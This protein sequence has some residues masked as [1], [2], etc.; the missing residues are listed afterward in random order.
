MPAPQS[1]DLT[2]WS[3]SDKLQQLKR[4]QAGDLLFIPGHVMMVLGVIDGEVWVIHDANGLSLRATGGQ[5]VQSKLNGVSVTP[6]SVLLVSETES[7]IDVMTNIQRLSM[8]P[9]R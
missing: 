5:F 6:L 9:L 2:A 7:Y 4:S 8:Q 3:A 1:L